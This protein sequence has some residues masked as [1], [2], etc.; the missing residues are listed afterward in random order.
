MWGS[1]VHQFDNRFLIDRSPSTCCGELLCFHPSRALP[2]SYHHRFRTH[3]PAVGVLSEAGHK[4]I[5][6]YW[7]HR[8]PNTLQDPPYHRRRSLSALRLRQDLDVR[9]HSRRRDASFGRPSVCR[10]RSRARRYHLRFFSATLELLPFRPPSRRVGVASCTHHPSY[11][12]GVY[13]S[14]FSFAVPTSFTVVIIVGAA[15]NIDPAVQGY[16]LVLYQ[17]MNLFGAVFATLWVSEIGKNERLPS[18]RPGARNPP[19]QSEYPLRLFNKSDHAKPPRVPPPA[20]ETLST[21]ASESNTSS[22][23]SQTSP[24]IDRLYAYETTESHR[25]DLSIRST[26]G[27]DVF[28]S[29]SPPLSSIV[30]FDAQQHPH[31]PRQL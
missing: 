11:Q 30:G 3:L 17:Y 25:K 18:E 14:L 10:I 9:S 20:T 21:S 12:A 16:F 2:Q 15:V 22:A 27:K 13:A 7:A 6:T 28:P 8:I 26:D 23:Q 4:P 31:R 5:E 1:S 24:S 29:P 19:R